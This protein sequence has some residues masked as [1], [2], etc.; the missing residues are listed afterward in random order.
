M[1]IHM[2]TKISKYELRYVIIFNYKKV[3]TNYI[4]KKSIL[5]IIPIDGHYT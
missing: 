4:K 5:C 3:Y 1:C 2:H